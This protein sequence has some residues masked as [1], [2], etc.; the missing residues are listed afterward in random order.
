MSELNLDHVKEIEKR[1]KELRL[2]HRDK[3][4]IFSEGASA[5]TPMT[6]AGST[7]RWTGE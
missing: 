7:R 5:T 2:K 1:K 4:S 3:L 6:K